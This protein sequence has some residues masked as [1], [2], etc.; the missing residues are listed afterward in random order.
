LAFRSLWSFQSAETISQYDLN[1]PEIV[2]NQRQLVGT[3][4][5][6]LANNVALLIVDFNDHKCI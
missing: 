5:E 6:V 2:Y 1:A 3:E 4:V